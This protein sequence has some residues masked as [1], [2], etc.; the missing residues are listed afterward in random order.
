[1]NA[2]P[3][4]AGAGGGGGGTDDTG[5]GA[6]NVRYGLADAGNSSAADSK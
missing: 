6:R 4:G 3:A 2:D 1:M 5:A